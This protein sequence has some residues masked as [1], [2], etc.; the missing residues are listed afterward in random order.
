MITNLSEQDSL[1]SDWMRELRDITI[2]NNR[3]QFRNNIY[4]IGQ[5]AAYE[6]S[7]HMTYN[8][9]TATTPLT[10]AHC[11]TLATQPVIATIMRAGL[12]LYNG[13]LS[14]FNNADSAFIGAYRRHTDAAHFEIAQGYVACPVL[15]GRPLILADP[16]L[17]TGASMIQTLNS[18]LEYGQPSHIHI[19]AVIA[20]KEGVD[21]VQNHLPNSHIWVGAIDNQLDANKYIVPGLGDA[22]DL[23]YG[24][25]LQH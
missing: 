17:A 19:V 15:T 21:T 24:E 14:Y 12:P 25:K 16:M 9:T 10:T 1:L 23:C 3:E 11:R 13:I 6:I 8:H 5:V 4:K 2:Q 22:G 18:L 7:R 20:S